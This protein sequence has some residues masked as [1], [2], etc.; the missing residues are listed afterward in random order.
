MQIEQKRNGKYV[1]VYRHKN[2][3]RTTLTK[4]F[5]LSEAS[6]IDDLKQAREYRSIESISRALRKYKSKL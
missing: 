4:D 2:R 5:I 6:S 1:A 3:F